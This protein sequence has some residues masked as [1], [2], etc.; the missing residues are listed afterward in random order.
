ML[1]RVDEQPRP[2]TVLRRIALN[3]IF[4]RLPIEGLTVL[5]LGGRDAVVAREFIQRG[6]RRVCVIDLD[7]GSL[8]TGSEIA[9]VKRI[10]GDARLVPLADDSVDIALCLDMIEHVK[11]D[12]QVVREVGR[13]LKED[14]V[15]LLTTPMST[16]WLPLT[17]RA[18]VNHQ[19]GH[20]RN[21]YTLDELRELLSRE[22]VEV[23]EAGLYHGLLSRFLYSILFTWRA[24]RISRPVA[25]LLFA[26]TCRL[27]G[28]F[29]WRG[30]E[31]WLI[32]RKVR[33]RAIL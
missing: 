8:C 4:D 33:R 10:R 22:G 20:V 19:W 24:E 30:R 28:R 25:R 14:G 3:R 2:G 5:D 26:V 17:F 18:A 31:H 15:L 29:L 13:V 6:A 9:Q 32:A 7:Q 12:D 27:E 1:S 16:F 11:E 23:T 21:G